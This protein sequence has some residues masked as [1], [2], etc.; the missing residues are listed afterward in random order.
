[1]SQQVEERNLF[2]LIKEIKEV[3]PDVGL[4]AHVNSASGDALNW[5]VEV[6]SP[7]GKKSESRSGCGPLSAVEVAEILEVAKELN[8]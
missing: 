7:D 6:K 1:M 3:A 5:H 8:G 2:P 4:M